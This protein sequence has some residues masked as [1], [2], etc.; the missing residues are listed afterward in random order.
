MLWNQWVQK[1]CIP[2]DLAIPA[3]I[4]VT[5]NEGIRKLQYFMY[6][7]I[8]LENGMCDYTGNN[9]SHGSS[10]KWFKEKL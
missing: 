2:L 8:S 3:D 9:W 1:T 7:D 10:N 4:N 6:R 5:R